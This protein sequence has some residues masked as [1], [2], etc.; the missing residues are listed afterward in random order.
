MNIATVLTFIGLGCALMYLAVS[1]STIKVKREA[2]KHFV[3]LL[4]EEHCATK[5][6]ALR[7][8]IMRDGV[9][10][11]DELRTLIDC[12]DRVSLGLSPKHR[13]S[14]LSG[15]HQRGAIGR[16]WYAAKLLNKAG[17]GSGAIPVPIT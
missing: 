3:E 10:S 16:A 8:E 15:L 9:A 6:R 1:I 11:Y 7:E 2:E 12:L 4:A 14:I 17:I 13:A 5:L